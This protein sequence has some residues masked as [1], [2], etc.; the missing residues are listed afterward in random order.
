MADP[1]IA[2]P[3]ITHGL[4]RAIAAIAQLQRNQ[5]LGDPLALADCQIRSPNKVSRPA[6]PI[7]YTMISE[8]PDIQYAIEPRD[9][10]KCVYGDQMRTRDTWPNPLWKAIGRP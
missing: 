5:N 2:A 8:V 3:A 10:E 9:R 7:S 4:E 6:E 1:M